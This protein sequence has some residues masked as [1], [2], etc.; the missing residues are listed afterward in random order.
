MLWLASVLASSELLL[1][2][3]TISIGLLLSRV[4]IASVQLGPAAVLFVGILLSAALG[5]SG[6]LKIAHQVKELGLV[7]FVYC[8]GLTSG[9]G[10]FS[11]FRSSGLRLNAGVLLALLAGAGCALAAGKLLQLDAGYVAGLFSGALTNTPALGAVTDSLGTS[12]LASHAALAYAVAYPFGVLGAVLSLRAFARRHRAALAAE[13]ARTAAL[14]KNELAT[15]NFE[16]TNDAVVGRTIGEL[17]IRDQ[18]GVLVSRI[19]RPGE[20]LVPTKYTQLKRGDV[21]TAVGPKDALEG[22]VHLFGAFSALRLETQRARVDMRRI[23]VSRRELAGRPLDTLELGTRFNAQVTRL[24]R[25]D[26]ELFPADSTRVQLGDRLRVVAPVE[27]L[28]ELSEFF[29]D[30]ERELS[31]IDLIALGSG[32]AAGLL[33]GLLPL[34]IPGGALTLGIAGGPLLV[35][36]ALGQLGRFG[37]LVWSLPQEASATLR[38]LGLVIFLA[39]VGVSAGTQLRAVQLADGLRLFGAGVAI[40]LV[41]SGVALWLFL[42]WARADVIQSLGACSGTQTQPA[43]LAVAHELSGQ[44][45]QTY[46]AYAIVYPVAMIAKIL[47]AQLLTWFA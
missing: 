25:G 17:R 31:Q 10:F 30:S 45:E 42:R 47:L 15:R 12:P 20:S 26:L 34:P 6:E 1:L 27:R 14:S 33:L 41:T 38:E 22:A 2:F 35:G 21:V 29:G 7:L 16:I 43:T 18:V 36:L 24:R 4:Q 46:V 39:G 5:G 11:T 19:G 8:V 28:H 44:S 40:T 13:Q 3:V 37:R 32:L 23:L 9:P